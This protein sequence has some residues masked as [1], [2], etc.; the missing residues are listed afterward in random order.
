M[1]CHHIARLG[2]VVVLLITASAAL[3]ADVG[4]PA[5]P[6]AGVQITRLEDR[7]RV[8]INGELF[9]E[10]FFKD[11]PPPIVT[12]SSAPATWR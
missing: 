3:S 4:A 9:T 5:S 2:F 8:E 10:Y 12:P 11:V 7:L 6:R 1:F